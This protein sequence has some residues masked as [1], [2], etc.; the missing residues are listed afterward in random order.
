MGS[1][2]GVSAP[3]VLAALTSSGDRASRRTCKPPRMPVGLAM[4]PL[5]SLGPR[6]LRPFD[7]PVSLPRQ[8]SDVESLWQR[9]LRSNPRPQ[10]GELSVW[11]YCDRPQFSLRQGVW[12][13]AGSPT[14]IGR[15]PAS[16]PSA[17]WRST[18][19]SR[20]WD[21]QLTSDAIPRVVRRHP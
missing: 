4:I 9:N 8:L 6:R 10:F 5:H 1:T 17:Q 19:T 15:K 3:A 11:Q 2:D 14:H 18:C 16:A 13:S 12:P 20:G 7:R 21:I